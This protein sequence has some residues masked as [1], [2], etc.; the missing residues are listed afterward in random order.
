MNRILVVAVL[1]ALMLAGEAHAQTRVRAVTETAEY[2]I[3]RYGAKAG[4]SVPELAGQIP[5]DN[6]FHPW[7]ADVNGIPGNNSAIDDKLTK[8]PEKK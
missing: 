2:L 6:A 8:P 1:C 3:G 7:D 4:R 5:V